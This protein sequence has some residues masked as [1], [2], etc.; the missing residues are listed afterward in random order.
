MVR[1]IVGARRPAEALARFAQQGFAGGVGA[2]HGVDLATIEFT[3]GFA[4]A[5]VLAL[6]R[7]AHTGGNSRAAFAC[8]DL[9]GGQLRRRERGHFDLD[10][11]AI[12]QRSRQ[13]AQIARGYFGRAAAAAVRVAA[14]AARAGV[15][16]RDQ[17]AGGGEIGLLGC[18]RNGDPTCF[19]RFAQRFEHVTVEFGQ[20]VEE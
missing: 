13:L 10:V 17:L 14:P 8:A 3:I 9:A 7:G 11:D 15:H 6:A 20:F 2:A 16:G 5:Y 18:P 19:E 1:A 4:L 12:Q